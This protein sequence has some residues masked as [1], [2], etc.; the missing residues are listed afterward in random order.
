MR[1]PFDVLVEGPFFDKSRANWRSFEP[2]AQTW[3]AGCAESQV[4]WLESGA[5]RD[6]GQHARTDFLAVVE[7]E[8][9]IMASRLSI[10][11]G[12]IPPVA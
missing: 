2:L 6:S 1:K 4:L 10:K 8:D 11:S 9:E 3:I 7:G 5:F 12:V